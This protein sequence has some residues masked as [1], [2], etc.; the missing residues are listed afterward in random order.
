MDRE[1]FLRQHPESA[2][3]LRAYFEGV[4]SVERMVVAGTSE[5]VAGLPAGGL[6]K[7]SLRGDETIAP[8]EIGDSPGAPAGPFAVLPRQFGRYRVEKLLGRGSMGAVYLAHDAQ[9]SRPVALK[10]PRLTGHEDGDII[11]RLLREAKAAANLNHPNICRVYDTGV[12]AGIFYIAMEYIEGRLLSD[13]ISPDRFQDERRS[14]N[15]VRKLAAALAEA[16]AKGIVHRDLKPGNILVNARG[17]PILTDFGLARLTDQPPE[18]RTTQSG[19]LIGSPAYMSPEQANG[20]SDKIGPRSDIYSLGVLLFELLTSRL[21]F[22]GSVLTILSQITTKE[23]P[24]PSSLRP[25]LDPR[26]DFL[27]Q[28]MMA[29]QPD[30][31]FASMTD[32]AREMQNWLKAAPLIVNP[33][34]GIKEFADVPN[35]AAAGAGPAKTTDTL[36]P[37]DLSQ[38]ERRA[39][40]LLDDQDFDAAIP[41]LVRL[42]EVQAALY[43]ETAAWASAELPLAKQ[44]QQKLRERVR[45]ACEKARGLLKTY[46]YGEAAQL[47]DALPGPARTEEARSLLTQSG[48]SFEECLGLKQEIDEAVRIKKY[49]QLLPLVRRFLK[50]KPDNAKMQRLADNLARSRPERAVRNYKGTGKYF[51]VAGRLV[52]PKE[53]VLGL[54]L[55]A[56]LYFGVTYGV[57]QYREH[58]RTLTNSAAPN[59]PVRDQAAAPI[60]RRD[61]PTAS[62]A[63]KDPAVAKE[64]AAGSTANSLASGSAIDVLAQG[65]QPIVG[66]WNIQSNRIVSPTDSPAILQLPYHL[67]DEYVLAL[68]VRRLSG[69]NT[70]AIGAPVAGQQVLV[71]LDAHESNVSGLEYLDGKRINENEAA[72]RGNLFVAGQ[73]AKITC[74]VRKDG[75]SCQFDDKNVIDWHGDLK[76][77]SLPQGFV[78][79]DRQALFIATIG[80]EYEIRELSIA[81][82]NKNG[83]SVIPGTDSHLLANGGLTDGSVMLPPGTVIDV[84]SQRLQP[85][86]GAWSI[87]QDRL[88]SP[89]DSP[90]LLQLPYH[91]PDEYVVSL[92]ARRISGRNVLAIGVPVRG[93]QVLIALD[94][95]ES[96]VSGLEYVDGKHVNENEAARRGS[97]FIGDQEAKISCTVR[98]DGITCLFDDVKV[99]DWNG[100]P[101]SLSLPSD[102]TVPDRKAPF[103]ATIGSRYE[104]RELTLSTPPQ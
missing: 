81:P 28:R 87:Q 12:E 31:R 22:Q 15:V 100:D 23:P 41:M 38:Q 32:V 25:G 24:A 89:V 56:A 52:E 11:N 83:P 91:P 94:A 13:F 72:R 10:V 6:H 51:D 45:A 29:K 75:I 18:S 58:L 85:V 53:A 82:L 14:V 104:I 69:N 84:L 57:G 80:S 55:V 96:N 63:V 50:L 86:K 98:K 27:C 33:A 71:A 44:R 74:V 7:P 39:R 66:T 2:E 30:D 49:D 54:V 79:P 88:V 78:V 93:R 35:Q 26:L 34:V 73:D 99:I 65:T 36:T 5:D 17:E 59:L 92:R 21:P 47:L 20:E 16:H 64:D 60:S 68:T 70:F 97:L 43:K 103:L 61:E 67:P 90:A 19:M 3:L 77:L 95:H 37:A 42:S 9:L 101:Q 40:K 62:A 1:E 102:F 46:N 76:R 8:R 4:E 48:D